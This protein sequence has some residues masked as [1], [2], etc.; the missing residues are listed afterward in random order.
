VRPV[1]LTI[2]ITVVVNSLIASPFAAAQQRAAANGS[3]RRQIVT[4]PALESATHDTAIIRWTDNTGGGTARHYG[5]VRYGTDPRRLDQI[6]KS[7]NRWS[8]NLP[9]MTYRVRVNG[10]TPGTTYY[11]RVDSAQADGI[12]MGLKSSTNQFTTRPRQ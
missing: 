6:A 2:A 4:G 8:R 10:L 1:L 3:E 12:G 7:P 11:Y 5:I 9:N